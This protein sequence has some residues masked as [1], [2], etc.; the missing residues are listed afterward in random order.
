M[1]DL[2]ARQALI[3]Y[4]MQ[5]AYGPK[6]GLAA[7]RAAAVL[8]M[9]TA[10]ASI[11]SLLLGYSRIPF[12]AARDAATSSAASGRLHETG[13]L[14]QGVVA[15]PGGRG[16]PVLFSIAR[17]GDCGAGRVADR[18]PVPAAAYRSDGAAANA[19]GAGAAISQSGCIPCRRC[20]RSLDSVIFC[21]AART[22]NG[23][24]RWRGQSFCWVRPAYLVRE[25]MSG[26]QS[27][28]GPSL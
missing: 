20:W 5:T 7:G 1:K 13:R 26:S 19:A 8:V 24:W 15:V 9:I 12:A 28:R 23:S 10:F 21:W 18:G 6:Y 11:F 4:F 27:F 22:T 14:S 17:A 3:S 2:G 25:R 16:D